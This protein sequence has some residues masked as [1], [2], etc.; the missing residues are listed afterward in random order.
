MQILVQVVGVA[1]VPEGLDPPVIQA[2]HEC[3][4]YGRKKTIRC[5]DVHRKAF[6]APEVRERLAAQNLTLPLGTPE[7]FAA[8]IAAE[9]KRW[10]DVIRAAKIKME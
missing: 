5:G 9:T 7:D 6:E 8:H 3:I 2:R 4:I 10:G 1:P